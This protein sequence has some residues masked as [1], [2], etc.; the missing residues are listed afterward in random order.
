MTDG[1]QRWQ[2][3]P[4]VITS[5]LEDQTDH[6][7]PDFFFPSVTTADVKQQPWLV[8]HFADP[9]GNLSLRVQALVIEIG[10][11]TVVVD[12]CVGNGKPRSQF[13]WNDQHWPFMERFAAAGFDPAGVDL[14]VHTH[15]HTDH[16]G[17]ATHLAGGRWVPTFMQA[18][19][20]YVEPELA[21]AQSNDDPDA[22]QIYAD[23]IEPVLAAG[24]GDIVA[25]DAELG[26]G[27]RL[28]PTAGHTPGH[29]SLRVDADDEAVL[30][31]GDVIHHPLQCAAPAVAFVSDDQPE[32]ARATRHELLEQMADPAVVM[33]GT[34]FPTLPLGQVKPHDRTWRYQPRQPQ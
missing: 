13:F 29:V 12:P 15:L 27:L 31:T 6:I 30:V 14:V 20:V 3:G 25:P 2:V 28:E 33:I 16:V 11:R 23:S 17:W 34:H 22:R 4:V 26:S 32:Q 18:R 1:V 9:D 5:I 10:G 21:W 19:H 24:L 8:P 7:P